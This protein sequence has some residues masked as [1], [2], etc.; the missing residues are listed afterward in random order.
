MLQLGFGCT[1][2]KEVECLAN[3]VHIAF[4]FKHEMNIVETVFVKFCK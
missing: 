4:N 2:F 1:A 3:W